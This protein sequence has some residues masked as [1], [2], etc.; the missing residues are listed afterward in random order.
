MTEQLTL[1]IPDIW[2]MHWLQIWTN[3]T[4]SNCLLQLSYFKHIILGIFPSMFSSTGKY[5]QIA[6]DFNIISPYFLFFLFTLLYF[7]YF[8]FKLYKIVWVLPNIKMNLKNKNMGNE[9]DWS[10]HSECLKHLFF[11]FFFFQ[12]NKTKTHSNCNVTNILLKA[13]ISHRNLVFYNVKICLNGTLIKS[14]KNS[15]SIHAI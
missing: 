13:G 2:W 3:T 11:Q 6:S 12:M 8:I 15:M 9:K 4:I 5:S 7:F 1:Y 14:Q 10:F